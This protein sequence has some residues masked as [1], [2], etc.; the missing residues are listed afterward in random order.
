VSPRTNPLGTPDSTTNGVECSQ[1]I[2][3][4]S[5]VTTPPTDITMRKP[6]IMKMMMMIIIII[7][8]YMQGS[9]RNQGSNSGKN[10]I[11]FLLFEI[12]HTGCVSTSVLFTGYCGYSAGGKEAAA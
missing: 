5:Y 2:K 1:W 12:T 10:K 3:K 8:C 11:I 6:I 4:N 7:I 9:W